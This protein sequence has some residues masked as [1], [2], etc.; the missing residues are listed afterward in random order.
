M[1]ATQYVLGFAFDDVGRVALI[2]KARPAWQ[3]N[4]WNGIG[5]H[6]EE[7]ESSRDAM[8]REF[9]EETG[10]RLDASLWTRFGRMHGQVGFE[11]D[12]YTIVHERIRNVQTATDEEVKLFCMWQLPQMMIDNVASLIHLSILCSK[13]DPQVA[14]EYK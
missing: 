4:Q 12:L 2:H 8:E 3:A 11:V 13:G 9:F 1:T 14:I 5:G 10:V 7:G 6:I